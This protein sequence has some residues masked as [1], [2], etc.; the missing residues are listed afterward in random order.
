MDKI[1]I[2]DLHLRCILG[3]TD[4]ERRERQGVLVQITLFTDLDRAIQSDRVE[5]GLDYRA[6]KKRVLSL[7]EGSSFRLLEALTA[8]IAEECTADPRVDR[9]IVRVDK[10]GALRFART[11]GIELTR[12]RQHRA[13][14]ALGSNIEPERNA[15]RAVRSLAARV[16]IVNLSTFYRTAPLGRPDGPPFVNGVLELST[17]R[18]PRALKRLLR[19]IEQDLGRVRTDDPNADRP[20]DLDLVLYDELVTGSTDLVLPD[21]DIRTRAFLARPLLE[22]APDLVLPGARIPIRDIARTLET[23]ELHD[24]PEL[25]KRLRGLIHE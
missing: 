8:R 19:K 13:F 15:E 6:L 23:S 5:D 7:V 4:A 25:T 21:P 16:P 22:L 11:V 24:L 3:I 18:R 1:I 2:G 17:R 10:P 20:I 14:V 9:A 12:R